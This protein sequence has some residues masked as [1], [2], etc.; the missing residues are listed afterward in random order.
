MPDLNAAEVLADIERRRGRVTDDQRFLAEHLPA[1]LAA[2]E[3]LY[4]AS[5]VADAEL[6]LKVREFIAIGILLARGAS[7]AGIERHMQR[8]LEHGATTAELVAALQAMIVSGGGPVF[9]RGLS[10]LRRVAVGLG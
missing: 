6:P 5:L 3:A 10:I 8:A 1:L 7:D 4:D 2:Y 9:N